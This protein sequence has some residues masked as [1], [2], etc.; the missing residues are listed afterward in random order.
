MFNDTQGWVVLD[1]IRTKD[2]KR[3]IKTKE[4]LDA[5]EIIELKKILRETYVD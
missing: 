3:I 4:F 2:R 1:Q 5:S